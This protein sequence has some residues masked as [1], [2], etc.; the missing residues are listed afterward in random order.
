MPTG[1]V[2]QGQAPMPTGGMHQGPAPMPTGGVQQIDPRAMMMAQRQ[3]QLPQQAA[4]QAMDGRQA[5]YARFMERFGGV[6]DQTRQAIM[7]ALQGRR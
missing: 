2:M 1:G 4:P 5:A 3:R 6:P 7:Q